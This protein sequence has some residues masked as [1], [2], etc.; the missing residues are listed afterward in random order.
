MEGCFS[1]ACALWNQAAAA[2]PWE[3]FSLCAD[4]HSYLCPF[5]DRWEL[6]SCYEREARSDWMQFSLML[7]T[8][9]SFPGLATRPP[10]FFFQAKN[11]KAVLGGER[12]A[13]MHPKFSSLIL[14]GDACLPRRTIPALKFHA[15]K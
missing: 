15:S 5:S 11:M 3:E 14:V 12:Y 7:L 13:K 10:L 4:L 6:Q 8:L 1:S 2:V 9:T